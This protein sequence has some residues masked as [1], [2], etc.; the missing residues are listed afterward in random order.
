MNHKN[1]RMLLYIW[2]GK[3]LEKRIKIFSGVQL[4]VGLLGVF[5]F[6]GERVLVVSFFSSV[7]LLAVA[8]VTSFF[9]TR[10]YICRIFLQMNS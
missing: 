9:P 7:F 8:V 3:L 6:C 2:S 1:N 10:C 4:T 5:W